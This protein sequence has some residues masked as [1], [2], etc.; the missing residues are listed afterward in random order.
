MVDNIHVLGRP[1]PACACCARS[2]RSS[3]LCIAAG[4]AHGPEAPLVQTTGTLGVVDRHACGARRCA[5]TRVAHDRGHGRRV[6]GAVRRA[7]RRRRCSPWR[8][9]TAAGSSTTRRSC[10]RCSG[11]LAGY[12]VYVGATGAGLE[13]VWHLPAPAS[14][15]RRRPRLGRGRRRRRRARRDRVHLLAPPPPRGGAPVAG[16]G[17]GRCSAGC[18]LAALGLRVDLLADVRRGPD[19][20]DP[21]PARRARSRSSPSPRSAKLA[22]HVGD[23]LVRVAGRLHHPA[24]L[25]GRVPRP[26]VPRARARHQRSGDDRGVHGGGQ[27][28]R[29]Q[30]A[31]SARRSWSP[32]WRGSGCCPTTL[33]RDDRRRSSSPARSASSTP[34]ASATSSATTTTSRGKGQARLASRPEPSHQPVSAW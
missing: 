4:G 8:C 2:F 6:H 11:S 21:R 14:A 20:R 27:R 9:C 1:R 26:R 24:V 33:H 3:L 34:S 12:A 15:P 22:R 7:A 31:R 23:P 28:R 25:H 13:P 17:C 32:R 29:H 18:C 19:Q 16:R 5:S 10:R 30:D